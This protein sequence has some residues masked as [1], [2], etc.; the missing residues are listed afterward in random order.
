MEVELLLKEGNKM[1]Q[2]TNILGISP[3]LIV[4]SSQDG[5]ISF[6]ET[7]HI[8]IQGMEEDKEAI[9]LLLEMDDITVTVQGQPVFSSEGP[10]GWGADM[11]ER[12]ASELLPIDD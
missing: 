2:L 7:K 12:I 1:V 3:E 10:S 11:V 4:F 5:T 8:R 9:F 6:A